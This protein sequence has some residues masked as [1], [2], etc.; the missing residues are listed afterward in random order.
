LTPEDTKRLGCQFPV[1]ELE[2]DAVA[3]K[4][5]LKAQN[6]GIT[7]DKPVM[8]E[9][10]CLPDP[11]LP[12]KWLGPAEYT[13]GSPKEPLKRQGG[14]EE[15]VKITRG[16]WIGRYEATQ[17]L[18]ES[19]MKSNPSRIKGSPYLPVNFISWSEACDFCRRFTE[20]ERSAGRCPDG[21]EYRLPTEAEWE[22]ACRAGDDPQGDNVKMNSMDVYQ[23]QPHEVGTSPPNRWGFYEMVAVPPRET[24]NVPE[25]CLD[26]FEWYPTEQK[27]VTV[28]RF[29]AGKPGID[30]FVVRGGKDGRSEVFPHPYARFYRDDSPGGFRGFRVVLGPKIE[31]APKA[32]GK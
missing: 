27:D 23:T 25:W 11:W 2:C 8:E 16:Y 3:T 21:Y 6:E 9:D 7:N 12:M 32:D 30:Q 13:M 19:V 1:R 24:S 31:L 14:G 28:D 20:K 17:G 26:R 18:W 15:R 4:E 10:Y 22:F 5:R 29:H